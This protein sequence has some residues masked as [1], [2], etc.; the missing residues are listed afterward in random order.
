MKLLLKREMFGQTS[1]IGRLSID[2]QH[3]CFILEDRVRETP[4]VPVKDW[5]VPG[6]TAIPEGTYTVVITWSPWF[7][8][9]LPLLLNVPG[10]EGVRIHPGNTEH[11]TEGCL[12]PGRSIAGASVRESVAAFAPLFAKIEAAQVAGEKVEI[13]IVSHRSQAAG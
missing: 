8:R 9:N 2:G 10:F 4:G 12:L 7:K 3:E 1:T 13:E 11:D 5:K 6:Q